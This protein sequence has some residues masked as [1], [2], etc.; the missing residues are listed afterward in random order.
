M[1][2]TSRKPRMHTQVNQGAGG[3]VRLVAALVLAAA[4]LWAGADATLT[5]RVAD[6][7]GAALKDAEVWA[8]NVERGLKFLTRTNEEGLYRI[9]YLS[10]GM[11]RVVLQKHGYRT[12]IRTDLELRVQDIIALNFEMQIG[13]VAESVT[14]V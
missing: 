8:I 9:L 10:P 11:Y 1:C 4:A 12:V 2:D 13:S 3:I 7:T 5:G 6:A 14:G